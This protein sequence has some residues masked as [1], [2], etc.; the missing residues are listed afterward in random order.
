ME[1]KNKA[2]LFPKIR[3]EER[4]GR[5]SG[6]QSVDLPFFLGIYIC[7]QDEKSII[8]VGILQ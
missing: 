4:K 2:S 6:K 8:F 3:F 7:E 1:R 5:L